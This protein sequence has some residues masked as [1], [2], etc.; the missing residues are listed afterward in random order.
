MSILLN[1][2]I[3]T[4]LSEDVKK[5]MEP[6]YGKA[7]DLLSLTK[8][9]QK[10]LKAYKE[11]MDKIYRSVNAKDEDSIILT[12]SVNEATSQVFLSIYLNYILTGRKNSVIIFSRAPIEE[13][14]LARFLES[15]G[16]RVYRI[17]PTADGTIDV[18]MLKE[19]INSKTALV[20][21][22]LVDDESGIIQPIEEVSIACS[23]HGV[24]LYCNGL[25]AIG[26]IP[27]DLQRD[28]I[29][30]LSFGGATINGP[31]DIAALYIKKDAP[32]FIKKTQKKSRNAT[33][34]TIY[35]L[36][37]NTI[38]QELPFLWRIR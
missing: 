33:F 3:T 36:N 16:C 1:S 8:E 25:N 37:T 7:I 5:E 6:F 26:R 22:P 30:Y 29:S 35:K 38:T 23:L 21:V 27:I 14:K 12:S 20:S 2:N 32:Q 9:N 19:Y 11:A 4:S 10:A 28:A 34:L 13:L 17:P 31:K 15:Q 18:D 24:G